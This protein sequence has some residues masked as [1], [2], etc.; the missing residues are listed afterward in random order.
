[1]KKIT[2]NNYYNQDKY[3]SNSKISDY[4]KDKHY[5][6][7][8]H[9]LGEI[10]QEITI[11]L[12]KGSAVDTWL[13]RGEMAFRRDYKVVTARSAKNGD[14]RWQINEPMYKQ[15]VNICQNVQATD[16]YKDLK[17]FKTQQV[18]Q[19]DIKIGLFKGLKGI[20][21]WFKID[22]NKCIIVDL[23]TSNTADPV[24]YHYHCLDYGYYRQA[25]TYAY[26]LSLNH[27]ELDTFT[28]RH[29]VAEKDSDDINN[30]YTFELDT[31]RVFMEKDNL[32][33]NILPAIASEKKFPKHN[34]SWEFP[35]VIGEVYR[36]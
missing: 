31:E 2:N 6:Y 26:I 9:I 19:F 14:M 20:P 13:T 23:K 18:I 1:M 15:I 7:R 36:D 28:F 3:L 22:G 29:L 11:P 16:A 5:F 10:K 21:D 35:T 25:A 32:V 8:K 24:K 27:P 12:V 34:C 17:D 30:V 4:L 33:D